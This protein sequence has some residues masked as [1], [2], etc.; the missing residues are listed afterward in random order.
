VTEIIMIATTPY[1]PHEQPHRR[2][3]EPDDE[4][5]AEQL[6]ERLGEPVLR[7]EAEVV[8]LGGPQAAAGAHR[9]RHVVH[10]VGLRHAVARLHGEVDAAPPHVEVPPRGLDGEH[11][12]RVVGAASAQRLE[13]AGLGVV[14]A[15]H[16]ER[17]P[18][19]RD[20]L[21]HRV[22]LAEQARGERVVDDHH[23]RAPPRSP[24]A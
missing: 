23:A 13:E 18:L 4:Q 11:R 16:E 22:A 17:L 1:A 2:E 8:R 6:V 14:D 15:D 7:D 20:R 19:D 5:R 24:G 21:A 10:G 9:R 3:R 12:A